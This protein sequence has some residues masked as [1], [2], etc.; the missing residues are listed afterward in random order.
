MRLRK[1]FL[2]EA[3]IE[4][5]KQRI[6]AKSEK[7]RQYHAQGSQCSQKNLFQCNQKGFYKELGGKQ[8]SGQAPLNAEETK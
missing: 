8:R 5:L 4:E 3:V 2:R 1:R 7:L 6:S